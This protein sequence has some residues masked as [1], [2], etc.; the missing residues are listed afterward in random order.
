MDATTAFLNGELKEDIYMKQP[1]G[2]AQSGKEHLVCKLKKSIYGLKQSPRC[3]NHFHLRQLSE[4]M[5]F[6]Q[7]TG[8][9]CL[10]IYL[11]KE[12]CF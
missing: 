7:A 11:Q 3:W 8:D 6:V 12:R 4:E 1:E 10:Y 5:G 2:Y 9:P